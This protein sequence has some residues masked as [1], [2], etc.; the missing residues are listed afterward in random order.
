MVRAAD[1]LGRIV[2]EDYGVALQFHP[3]AD[4]HVETQEQT[5]RFLADTDPRYVNLCL[6]TGHLAYRRADSVELI[7]RYPDRIGYV[8]I[9]QM[10]PAIVATG[11]AGGPGLRPGGG[12]RRVLR[13]AAG[14]ARRAL[15]RGG[16][17]RSWTPS[18]FVVVE[19]DMYPVDFDVPAPIAARTG[20]TCAPSASAADGRLEHDGARRRRR[21]RHDRPG[22][23]PPADQGAVRSGRGRGRPMWTSSGRE[24]VAGGLRDATVHATGEELIADD[25]VD[26]VVVCS[27]G[28][29][30]EQ[31]VLAAI[32]AG[33]PVF[34]E[35]P[36]ATTPGGLPADPRRPRSRP[37]GGWSRSAT[38]AGT[39]R[40]TARCKRGRR[41]RRIDRRCRCSCTAPTATRACRPTTAATMAST[42]PR[43]TRSTWC[44]GCS[45]RR[46]RR[47][48]CCA[49][50]RTRHSAATCRTR[51]SCCWR[52]ASGSWSTSRS[53]VNIRYGYD[54]RGEVVGE[55]GTATL[56]EPSPV[57]VRRGG[58]VVRPGAARTGASGSSAR[59]TSSCRSGSTRSAADG[60]L[61]PSSWDGYAATVVSDAGLEALR[62]GARVPVPLV[63][64]PAC[65]RSEEAGMKLAL[66]PYM[67]RTTP[68][69]RAA[70][71]GGRPR[72]RV[73]RA[74]A[75]GG[76]H[77]V[78]PAPA[79]EP[80]HRRG[81]SRPSST[82]PA[83]RIASHLPLYRWS[84]PDED[85]R[86]AAVRYWKRAIQLTVDL[87][88]RVMN[89]EF[90][91]R[92]EQASR[93]EAQFWRS[94][95][96]LLPVFEREG[97]QLRLEPHPD[98]FV[99]DGRVA[100][101]MVRG[102]DSDLVSFL[103]CAPHTFHQASAGGDIAGIMRVRGR[104]AHPGARGR[105][106]R[107]PGLQSGCATS[108]T[109]RAR[110]RG[111]TSTSTSAR[112]RSTGTSSSARS[113]SSASAGGT[114][115]S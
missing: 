11:R 77:P 19:Q 63:D 41:Q 51:W 60:Q 30:H 33:K 23:H 105:L 68:L 29:T 55:S 17:V 90:N 112:A 64:R 50:R 48:G 13:A 52:P 78:L 27:W 61:G 107:P 38:C 7:R 57:Q 24:A 74:V 102:I 40:P 110:P 65:T 69:T 35:K 82:R 18:V 26:A 44:G 83:C 36:L 104:P 89:S 106:V 58:T 75:A 92:P 4:S 39:T 93:S 25:R 20:T 6:D 79:G 97:V 37:A 76:L 32:A 85:E 34:C 101:D 49:P 22:P 53:S 31:Y 115:R 95:E 47:S 67:L 10:D 87:D 113:A 42:T 72:L 66:D 108:S 62:T 96:E 114:R 98:D 59:T 54:I 3:H 46:S 45:A 14:P 28:P 15:G 43:C 86:Q 109:R 100:V 80:G 70:R 12:A 71:R 111:S 73:D 94:M 1:E 2:A 8:H 9:K 99:E 5:E 91:G 56:A 81:G 16:T 103:Y 88:C 21:G 84:G